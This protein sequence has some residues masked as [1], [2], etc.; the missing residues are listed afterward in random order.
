MP[1]L[2]GS[3]ATVQVEHSRQWATTV[4]ARPLFSPSRRPPE[5]AITAV[6]AAAGLPRLTAI[7]VTD[8]GR[9]AIF[10]GSADG[11]PIIV[12]EGGRIGH[13]QVQS[14]AASQVTVSGPD[15][16]KRLHPSFA[17]S[18]GGG[19]GVTSPAAPPAQ[20]SILDLLRGVKPS[21]S[22][23]GLPTPHSAARRP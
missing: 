4:L 22:I 9:S 15:G 16:Q 3:A 7:L 1:A 20:P 8:A 10:A 23:P 5:A 6:A 17:A 11:K 14:I 2:P 18:A 12:Q 13:Y 21:A 19:L